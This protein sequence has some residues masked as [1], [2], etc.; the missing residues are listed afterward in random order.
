[1]LSTL[2][3]ETDNSRLLMTMIFRFV[4]D[5]GSSRCVRWFAVAEAS[6]ASA[7]C[8]LHNNF[9]FFF[10]FNPSSFF[11]FCLPGAN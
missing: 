5:G 1:M 10:L 2:V 11:F 9:F 8:P 4:C 3:T 6:V 7:K